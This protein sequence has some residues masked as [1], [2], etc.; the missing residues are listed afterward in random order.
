MSTLDHETI[1]ARL[2]DLDGWQLRDG[3]IEREW[4]FGDF[5]EA[6]AFINRVAE[7]AEA[8]DHHPDLH[9]SYATVQVALTT[10]SEGGVTDK[11]LELAGRIDGVV[12]G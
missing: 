1:Q 8:A 6:I 7:L 11:D 3:T 2:R 9:N 12:A 5:G 10:H 4:R